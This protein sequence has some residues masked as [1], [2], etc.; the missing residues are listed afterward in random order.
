MLGPK[1]QDFWKKNQHTQRKKSKKKSVDERQF[2][3]KISFEYVDSWPKILHFRTQHLWNSTTELILIF[4][5]HFLGCMNLRNIYRLLV[6]AEFGASWI[7]ESLEKALE[8]RGGNF[9]ELDESTQFLL[10]RK[11]YLDHKVVQSNLESNF[12]RKLAFLGYLGSQ[13]SKGK[14]FQLCYLWA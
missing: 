8:Y 7:D 12:Q 11:I 9:C 4:K 6:Y 5:S 3:K 13:G 2:V 1:K 10:V 14:Q